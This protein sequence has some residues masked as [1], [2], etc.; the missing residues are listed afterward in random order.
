MGK[1]YNLTVDKNHNYFVGES[2][3]LAHN[4]T[5]GEHRWDWNHVFNGSRKGGIHHFEGGIKPV[6]VLARGRRN[7]PDGFYTVL[8]A[9]RWNPNDP[10]RLKKANNHRTTL[11]P[12][13]WSK[14]KVK[15]IY[16]AAAMKTNMQG[17]VVRLNSIIPGVSDRISINVHNSHKHG[18]SG[19]PVIDGLQ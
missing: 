16:W 19:W 15:A 12:D 11:F 14:Q 2:Q 5:C 17:G 13:E 9:K 1:V 3:V 18:W 4:A 7:G 10:L 6:G 8:V